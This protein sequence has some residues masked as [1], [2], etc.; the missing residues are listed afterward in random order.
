VLAYFGIFFLPTALAVVAGAGYFIAKGSTTSQKIKR[1]FTVFLA[2]VG[3]V[4]LALLMVI[5]AGIGQGLGGKDGQ[6][7]FGLLL[8]PY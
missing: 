8:L 1:V 2:F 3:L 4:I 7:M 6:G 5:G